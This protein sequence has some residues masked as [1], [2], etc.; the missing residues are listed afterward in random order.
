MNKHYSVHDHWTDIAKKNDVDI[1]SIDGVITEIKVNG[2]DYGGGGGESDFSTAE[3]TIISQIPDTLMIGLAEVLVDPEHGTQIYGTSEVVGNIT[4]T[5]SVLFPNN[6]ALGVEFPNCAIEATGD[7]EVSGDYAE[8]SGNGTIT[9]T[10]I[11]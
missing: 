6:G 4:S 9:I 7:I 5:F 11:D 8:I 1:E 3:L 2:E 10:G